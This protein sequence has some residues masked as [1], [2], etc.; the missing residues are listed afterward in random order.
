MT[1][2]EL[3]YI[4]VA[5][6]ARRGTAQRRQVLEVLVNTGFQ[7]S[8]RPA[9]FPARL[10]AG[11]TH[12][13]GTHSCTP[14][15]TDVRVPRSPH[16]LPIPPASSSS[17]SSSQSGS[18]RR[19]H[20]TFH[21]GPGPCGAPVGPVRLP[22]RAFLKG[23]V[24]PAVCVRVRVRAC[25]GGGVC[26]TPASP[27]ALHPQAAGPRGSNSWCPAAHTPPRGS[28]LGTK[29]L[30]TPR[31]G[32]GPLPSHPRPREAPRE[33]ADRGCWPCCLAPRLLS[34]RREHSAGGR[35]AGKARL[36]RS[37]RVQNKRP[38]AACPGRVGGCSL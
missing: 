36:A 19:L 14:C 30:A 17:S 32:N 33:D 11:D 22:S 23:R 1:S 7:N 2:T 6:R 4:R 18:A 5:G 3:W 21:Q 24:S 37:L 12:V 28:G 8:S 20:S 13:P 25:A 31:Q 27:P 15:P 10:K 29:A 9:V 16:F 34:A 38:P 26:K 35:V